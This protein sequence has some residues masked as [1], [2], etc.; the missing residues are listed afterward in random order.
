MN[1]VPARIR[2]Y[3]PEARWEDLDPEV[4]PDAFMER[5]LEYGGREEVKW[6]IATYG[7]DAIRD[8]L[9][10]KGARRLTK[11]SLNFWCLVLALPE[12]KPHPWASTANSLWGR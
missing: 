3:F 2:S 10:R 1:N 11:R 4:Y 12:V 6:L 8:F 7:P 5:V 9:R